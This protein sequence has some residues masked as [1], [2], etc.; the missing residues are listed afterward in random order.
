[1][2]STQGTDANPTKVEAIKKLQR[3]RS[4]GEIQKLEGM[5]TSL[6]RFISKSGERGIPFY[7]LLR[8]M[9]GFQWDN[10]AMAVFN[11]LNQYLKS[12]PTLI[13]P[14]EDDVLLLYIVT[15]DTVISTVIAVE[16]LEANIEVKQ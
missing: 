8:K 6:S 13:P 15:T 3:P 9:A 2:V 10:Q 14:K 4:R 12:L 11:E 16:R 5:M 7:K 1:M